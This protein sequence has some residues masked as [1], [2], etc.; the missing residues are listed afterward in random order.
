M[1]TG[2]SLEVIMAN[3][4]SQNVF[5]ELAIGCAVLIACRVSPSQKA[6]MVRLVRENVHPKPVTLAVGDGANDV[7]MIQ[8][9]QVGIGL[10][11]REGRQSVNSSDFAIGQFSYLQRLLLVHGRWNYRRACKYTLFT[12]WRNMVQVLMIVYYTWMAAYSAT[13]LFED[14]IRLSFNF[15]C[16]MPILAVGCFDQ[17]V[18]AEVAL[19]KPT[20][21][22]C[23]RLGR[24]LN[25]TKTLYTI[26][27]AFVH[28]MVLHFVTI[29]AFPSMALRDSGDYYT[30]GTTCYTCLLLDVNYR[31]AF[32]TCN[33]NVFTM[34]AIIMS[35]ILYV[36]Y[37]VV[38]PSNPFA[39]N[40]LEPNM[41]QVPQH[42][43]KSVYFWFC[44]IA[45]PLLAMMLDVFLNFIYHF[46]LPDV[47]DR[48][49]MEAEN[50]DSEADSMSSEV[51]E[52]SS[53]M[54]D[55]DPGKPLRATGTKFTK[56]DEK[57]ID[58]SAFGQQKLWSLRCE[59]YTFKP[60][61]YAG[62]FAGFL[63]IAMGLTAVYYSEASAQVRI[64]YADDSEGAHSL[65]GYPS[66][67]KEDE[68]VMAKCNREEIPTTCTATFKVPRDMKPPI[69]LYYAISPFYQNYGT[70]LKSESSVQL[71][72]L[73]VSEHVLAKTCLENSTRYTP[74]GAEIEPCGLKAASMFND[75]Y[76]LKGYDIDKTNIAWK[77][78]VERYKNPSS[79]P[80]NA[81]S[82]STNK[83]HWWLFQQFPTV[84]K[85]SE[86]VDNEAFITWM[87]PSAF[88]DIWNPVGWIHKKI[89]KGEEL[90]VTIHSDFPSK[91]LQAYKMLVFTEWGAMGGR[92]NEFGIL[93]VVCGGLC[94]FL[95]AFSI[96]IGRCLTQGE[97]LHKTIQNALD[98]H[99][100]ESRRFSRG[101]RYSE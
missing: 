9:A 32:L 36:V 100:M 35:C 37:L 76:E 80:Y 8:E 19:S 11:G 22:N 18:E 96:C 62:M 45:V 82:S 33:H 93:L 59:N 48:V 6:E 44:V 46:F 31:A 4:D 52:Q 69:L 71:R 54:C 98:P 64:M 78:D 72:G 3:E 27:S 25:A 61:V 65:M 39:A 56:E 94:L 79:Y 21:Y 23:G 77:S 67:T 2:A 10:A 55:E 58:L 66:G 50:S 57:E 17:D 91:P 75:T 42:M 28:S 20:L 85:R 49:H 92:H 86:G 74:S 51:E 7:P 60:V 89:S 84:V 5:L 83:S 12:F 40:K 29:L 99:A 13:C 97:G 70:Y 47:R 24:D 14:W 15:L 101:G 73:D 88:H 53:S 30:F 87:R 16:T 90:E 1:V 43:I 41:L 68:K 38:Y 34:G 26:W 95:A 81:S 63:C